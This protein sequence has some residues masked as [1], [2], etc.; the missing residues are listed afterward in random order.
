MLRFVL[1]PIDDM[2]IKDLRIALFNYLVAKQRN[3]NLLVLI[4]DTDTH[5][6]IEGKDQEILALLTLFGIKYSQVIHQTQNFRFY[7]AMALDLLHK[8]KAFSCFCS[9]EWIENKKKEA[10]K[11]N[12]LYSY[13]DACRNLPPELVIDNT[14]PFTIRIARPDKS[15]TIHDMLKGDKSFNPDDVDSFV[16]LHQDKTPTPTFAS[17]IDSM[18]NDISIIIRE[19]DYFNDTAR[20][21]HIQE[22]LG[23]QKTIKYAHLPSIENNTIFSNIK[24]LLE[25]G[26]LPTAIVNYLI[27]MGNKTP[28]KIFT[29]EEALEWF[30]LDTI[31]NSPTSFDLDTLKDIN[32]EHLRNMDA[33]ELSRYVGFADAEIGELARIYLKEVSTTKELKSKIKPIFSSRN[34]FE[35]FKDEMREM[36][37]CI[38]KAPYFN[39]YNDF[40]NHIMKETKI[41]G[42]R[43]EKSLSI[44]LTN[45]QD[46]PDIAKIYTYLKNYIGEIIK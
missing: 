30:T 23:Y 10:K 15:I 39:E 2:Q 41:E 35:D 3:K 28:C 17:A 5:K 9:S 24:L 42:E 46:C 21:Q 26:F 36:T 43:F 8:K 45:A 6:N 16:I 1:R 40:K 14:A 11:L 12:K 37:L 13:D 33:K 22:Q 38:K 32:K 29:L 7:S 18:L 27:F 4:E 31:V 34:V 25:E 44:L 19:E 20:E